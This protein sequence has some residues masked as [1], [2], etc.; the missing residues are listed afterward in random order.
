MVGCRVPCRTALGASLMAAFAA[1][2]PLGKPPPDAGTAPPDSGSVGSDGGLDGSFAA[3]PHPPLPILVNHGGPLLTGVSLVTV[4]WSGDPLAT[5]LSTFDGWLPRSG[6]WTSRLGEYG[7]AAGSQAASWQAPGPSPSML[8][9]AALRALLHEA[10]DAG[11]VPPPTPQRLYAVYPPPGTQV[12]ETLDGGVYQGC[13]DFTGYHAAE[14]SPDAGDLFYAV[15]PRCPQH[16]LSAI[17]AM[18]W[19]ASHEIAEASSDPEAVFGPAAPGWILL[20]PDPIA[21]SGG[22]VA[23]LCDGSSAV[24]EGYRVAALYSNVAAGGG[25]RPCLPSA[26]GPMFGADANPFIL[27]VPAGSSARTLLSVY[28]TAPL[29]APLTLD[30]LSEDPALTA[31]AG[32]SLVQNGDT[33]PLD[34]AVSDQA[35]SGSSFLI[36]IVAGSSDYQSV[37]YVLVTVP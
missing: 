19:P 18:T 6:Y 33:V 36:E 34:L 3:A 23:D 2:G 31:F 32:R 7:L 22:E 21:P 25:D 11:F 26:P 15:V 37:T 1:C 12:T 35:A 17:D 29:P 20:S 4:T 30:I 14:P 27:S 5:E 13:V 10:I 24:V 8:S 28:S 9:D 16:G